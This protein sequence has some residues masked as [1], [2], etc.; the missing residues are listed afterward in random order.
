MTDKT[1]LTEAFDTMMSYLPKIPMVLL[2]LGIGILLI[3]FLKQAT[4]RI[5]TRM[6]LDATII[7]FTNAFITFAMWVFLISI[8]FSVLGFPQ[9]SLA[10]SGSIALVLVGVAS[11]ANSLIQDLLAGL[12]LIADSDF[13]VGCE[14]KVNNVTGTV[15][16]LDIKKTKIKDENGHIFV[17]SN[18]VFDANIYEITKKVA[19]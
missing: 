7:S 13:K 1:V 4:T 9:I 11:N 10:F 6:R 18:K 15:V 3:R 12:F 8:L 14:V 2:T 16:G 19:E 17:V 5:M